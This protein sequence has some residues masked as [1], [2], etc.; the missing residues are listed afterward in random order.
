M[1]IRKPKR[2]S[3]VE[4][5]T[6][7]IE[8]L[9]QQGYWKVGEKIPSEIDLMEQFDISRNTLREALRALAHVGLLETKQGSGTI[10]TSMSMFGA[11]LSK[12]V[13]HRSLLQILEVR[14]A[15]ESEAAY[16]AA[17]RRTKSDIKQMEYYIDACQTAFIEGDLERFLEVDIAFHQVI[18]EASQ[19]DLLVDLYATLSDSLHYSVESNLI[20]LYDNTKEQHIH[21][22][23]LTAIKEQQ[24]ETA[25]DL[26]R[27]YLSDRKNQLDY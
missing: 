14:I 7:Q 25:S 18:V 24:P 15:L 8:D 22:Q 19:N 9:I 2:L 12:H 3:L 5:A 6:K 20:D 13:E 23:L 26:V 21:N 17:K 1:K 11:V 16:L 10:V 4:Q 27:T